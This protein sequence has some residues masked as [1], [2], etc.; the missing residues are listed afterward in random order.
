MPNDLAGSRER[1]GSRALERTLSTPQVDV[2]AATAQEANGSLGHGT[3]VGHSGASS[4]GKIAWPEEQVGAE[5][6]SYEQSVQ[7]QMRAVSAERA[8]RKAAQAKEEQLR[9]N[10]MIAAKQAARNVVQKQKEDEQTWDERR[11][12]QR[13]PSKNCGAMMI[14]GRSQPRPSA[15]ASTCGRDRT[16]RD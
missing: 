9:I 6:V 14:N 15:S 13:P 2:L 16:R 5:D 1:V 7:R 3:S 10:Q 12:Q 4:S 8:Q 11:H